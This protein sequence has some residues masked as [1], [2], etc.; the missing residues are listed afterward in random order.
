MLSHRTG[1]RKAPSVSASLFVKLKA[2]PVNHLGSPDPKEE[3]ERRNPILPRYDC[4]TLAQAGAHSPIGAIRESGA[5]L[6]RKLAMMLRFL[7]LCVL[8]VYL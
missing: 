4:I 6:S 5:P 1:H 8:R 7:F 3:K 2:N